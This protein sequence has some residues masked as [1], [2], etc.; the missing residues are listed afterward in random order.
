MGLMRSHIKNPFFW[1]WAAY[2]GFV[3]YGTLIPF[4][5]DFSDWQQKSLIPTAF[6][7]THL[8]KMDVISNF[9]F[10]IPWGFLCTALL[11]HWKN[12]FWPSL[13]FSLVLSF[14]L[15]TSVEILQNFS[16][17]RSPWT[18]DILV[19]TIGGLSGCFFGYF[20]FKLIYPLVRVSISN[21]I[22]EKPI[23]VLTVL[24]G[25]GIFLGS[26]FP[27]DI[28][29][30]VSD[31]KTALKS[32]H[33]LPFWDL[34]N[35]FYFASL[36]RD[37]FL[38][39][40]FGGFC[41]FSIRLYCIHF[42]S[43]LI[44]AVF[45]T[46]LLSIVIEFCQ[47]FIISRMVD[48]TDTAIA[49]I[50]GLIGCFISGLIEKFLLS[51]SAKSSYEEFRFCKYFF[52]FYTLFA[53]YYLLSPLTFNFSFDEF[54]NSLSYSLLIPF[55]AYYIHTDFNALKDLLVS[56]CLF[57][58]IGALSFLIWQIKPLAILKTLTFSLMLCCGIEL[59]QFFQP[60][61]YPDITDVLSEMTGSILGI[62][63]VKKFS[64]L[65]AT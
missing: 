11:R 1:L 53:A 61:H 57:I 36:T 44:R 26:L 27:F 14:L 43:F 23:L 20:F 64:P 17:S 6:K 35:S 62:W 15:S 4:D 45:L 9:L 18:G 19:N 3:F 10:F 40:L 34:K 38:F 60:H 49:L 7:E 25:L 54:K 46:V 16:P 8:S 65:K 13:I 29:I 37:L 42:K 51:Q 21:S 33:W 28:S 39:T 41:H 22:K 55:Y 52:V 24:I 30:Q 12:F 47:L 31:I 32:I 2:A 48:L 56:V 63:S 5:L 58:P 59:I 50:G